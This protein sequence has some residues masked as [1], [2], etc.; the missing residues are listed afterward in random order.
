MPITLDTLPSEIRLKIYNY[1]LSSTITYIGAIQYRESKSSTNGHA[2]C[3]WPGMSNVTNVLQTC[4]LFNSEASHLLFKDKVFFISNTP[5]NLNHAAHILN[6]MSASN[7][8]SVKGLILHYHIQDSVN[9][10]SKNYW[11]TIDRGDQG[12]V[13]EREEL[14]KA[15]RTFCMAAAGRLKSLGIRIDTRKCDCIT[16]ETL[17]GKAHWLVPFLNIP[18]LETRWLSVQSP[19][20]PRSP[21]NETRTEY[22]AR[23]EQQLAVEGVSIRVDPPADYYCKS[24]CVRAT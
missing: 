10:A 23:I 12:R 2:R 21:P 3:I 11:S 18:G 14:V 6:R 4:R 8:R 16:I 22:K 17:S 1:L 19:K 15:R 13:I 7:S 20:I 5:D 24:R 9:D